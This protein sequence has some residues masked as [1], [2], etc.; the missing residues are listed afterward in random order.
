[1]REMGLAPHPQPPLGPGQRHRRFLPQ[2]SRDSQ[3]PLVAF[4]M[5]LQFRRR[6]SQSLQLLLN[7]LLTLGFGRSRSLPTVIFGTNSLD[8]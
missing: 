2:P 1:M 8:L 7:N 6:P 5:A 4:A 3:L